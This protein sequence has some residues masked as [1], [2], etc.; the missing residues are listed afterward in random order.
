M[1]WVAE[2]V[3]FEARLFPSRLVE[4]SSCSSA[5]LVCL[6]PAAPR[7]PDP[8]SNH[9][10]CSSGVSLPLSHGHRHALGGRTPGSLRG[11]E[12]ELVPAGMVSF[13]PSEFYP[14]FQGPGPPRLGQAFPA[15]PALWG[16]SVLISLI[17]RFVLVVVFTRQSYLFCQTVSSWESQ[18]LGSSF[19]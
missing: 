6:A 11:C 18:D 2:W 15:S 12:I 9:P 5:T 1:V 17:W 14:S 7:V 10:A 4:A 19:S 16:F 3:G 13:L 8:G